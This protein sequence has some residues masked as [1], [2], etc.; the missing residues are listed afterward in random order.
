MSLASGIR[1]ARYFETPTGTRRSSSPCRSSVG[2]AIR[3]GSNFIT[4]SEF[5]PNIYSRFRAALGSGTLHIGRSDTVSRSG[6]N[7][8]VQRTVVNGVKL[9]IEPDP[10]ALEETMTTALISRAGFQSVREP[11]PRSNLSWPDSRVDS[12]QGA[13]ED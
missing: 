4:L 2:T 1:V 5:M 3:E 11:H 7:V 12:A 10:P 6:E 9:Q 8:A 13:P